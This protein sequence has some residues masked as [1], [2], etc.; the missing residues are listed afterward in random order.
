MKGF[1]L[2]LLFSVVVVL[3]CLVDGIHNRRARSDGDHPEGPPPAAVV[4]FFGSP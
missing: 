4:I 2:V 1:I 3:L